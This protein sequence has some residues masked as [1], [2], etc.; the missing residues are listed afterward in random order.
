MS[1]INASR[2]A[3]FVALAAVV[4]NLV[5]MGA[6]GAELYALGDGIARWMLPSLDAMHVHG[7]YRWPISIW[8]GI[9]WPVGG[10]AT[11]YVL[12]RTRIAMSRSIWRFP[13][14]VLSLIALAVLLAAL[15]HIGGALISQD[16]AIEAIPISPETL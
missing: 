4:V 7:D 8:I 13:A 5:T 12:F 3:L 2:I 11:W 16:Q 15:F 1:S 10:L 6:V 14:F 9:A